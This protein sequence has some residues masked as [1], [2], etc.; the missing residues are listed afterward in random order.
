M[1][2]QFFDSFFYISLA[3][4]F[5]LILLMVFHFKNRIHTLEEK[6]Q[7]LSEMCQMMIKELQ[8]VKHIQQHA[9]IMPPT[10]HKH[11]PDRGSNPFSHIVETGIEQE[12][13]SEV[14]T[15]VYQKIT[16]IDNDLEE[17][18][19]DLETDI[20]ECG[21]EDE[22]QEESD[23]VEMEEV[24]EVELDD[25]D[26]LENMQFMNY[27]N[28]DELSEEDRDMAI[29]EML[30]HIQNFDPDTHAHFNKLLSEDFR[31]KGFEG[32]AGIEVIPDGDHTRIEI[33][34]ESDNRVEEISDSESAECLKTTL[35]DTLKK[36][37]MDNTVE[38]EDMDIQVLKMPEEEDMSVI[39]ES[40]PRRKKNPYAKMT[41]QM[42]RTA[43]I[44]KGLMSD[45]SKVKKQQLVE[46]LTEHE[47][48]SAKE[49]TL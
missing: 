35:E 19:D 7:E 37:E 1:F 41:V 34:R 16:V 30:E 24:D 14:E 4:T 25:T 18:E 40:E 12:I 23:M 21:D 3:I 20:I 43:V 28:L 9:V 10:P 42:L 32:I 27:S 26:I 29:T 15:P 47:A 45:P 2:F 38:T 48:E 49:T 44:S 5:G 31:R 39:T 8:E 6:N 36:V 46:M 11:I 13:E 17:D 22:D 33:K